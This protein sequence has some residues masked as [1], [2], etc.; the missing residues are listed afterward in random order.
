MLVGLDPAIRAHIGIAKDAIPVS[1]HPLAMAG[2]SPTP[3][4]VGS[5][6]R[7]AI[8]SVDRPGVWLQ[9]FCNP[10][11]PQHCRWISPR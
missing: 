7:D 9:A 2:S 5:A 10:K 6:G 4:E 11:S 3:I 8:G 1:K